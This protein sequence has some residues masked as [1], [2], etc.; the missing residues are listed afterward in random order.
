MK[1][2]KGFTLI[3]LLV[4]IAI[5]A[6]LAAILFPVFAR[7]REAARTSTCT[8]NLNQLGKA[9]KSYM[10]DWED[11]F[12]TNRLLTSG[13]PMYPE[14][15]L[16]PDSINSATGQPYVFY[17]GVNWVEALYPYVERVGKPGDN[18]AVWKCPSTRART[19]PTGAT[20]NS[21]TYAFNYNLLEQPEGILKVS[22]NTMM[23]REL[24]SMFGAACRPK[25]ICTTSASVPNGP[26]LTEVDP[27]LGASYKCKY[28]LH[29][30]GSIILFADGHVKLFSADLYPQTL[31]AAA[32][33]DSTTN[34][35]WNSLQPGKK[36]IAIN[37]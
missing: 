3:E 26:F 17:Y 18:Q 1:A 21:N 33:W 23:I 5:I 11:T 14:I 32:N 25:N 27:T 31:S 8:A 29:G 22:G 2:R 35:W 34:Q 37:P 7:A 24:E 10:G 28:K 19:Y 16:S 15:P 20:Y 36:Q 9:V 30:N 13:S 12:P 6:I 4:V